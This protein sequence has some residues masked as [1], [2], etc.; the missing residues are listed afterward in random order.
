MSL[1]ETEM[2][3]LTF[4]YPFTKEGVYWD[5]GLG[6]HVSFNKNNFVFLGFSFVIIF[7]KGI[8][9][10]YPLNKTQVY[11]SERTFFERL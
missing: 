3:Q 10:E 9:W 2:D 11:F 4:R 5:V 1:C 6:F 7:L 8:F